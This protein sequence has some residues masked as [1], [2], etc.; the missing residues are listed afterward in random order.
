[1]LRNEKMMLGNKKMMLRRKKTMLG[2]KKMMLRK[3]F[4]PKTSM[5]V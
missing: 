1:M 5:E 2:N 4:N 3:N